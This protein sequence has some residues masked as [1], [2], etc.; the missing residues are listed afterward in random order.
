MLWLLETDKDPLDFADNDKSEKERIEITYI[1]LFGF[2]SI[3]SNDDGEII[4]SV[5]SW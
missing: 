2:Y 5:R 1:Q 4:H 3:S